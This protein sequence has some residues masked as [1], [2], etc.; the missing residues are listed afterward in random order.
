MS[1]N[2]NSEYEVEDSASQPEYI[3][4]NCYINGERKSKLE[5]KKC[6]DIKSHIWNKQVDD[7]F[8]FKMVEESDEEEENYENV[9]LTTTK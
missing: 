5:R 4:C 9:S 3:K 1:M 2:M 8:G 6:T 7:H